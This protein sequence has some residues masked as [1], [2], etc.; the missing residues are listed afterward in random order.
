MKSHAPQTGFNTTVR[1]GSYTEKVELDSGNSATNLISSEAMQEYQAN[2]GPEDFRMSRLE[3]INESA[4]QVSQDTPE[5]GIDSACIIRI[6]YSGVDPQGNKTSLSKWTFCCGTCRPMADRLILCDRELESLGIIPR[7]GE[8]IKLTVGGQPLA[9]VRG[10][11]SPDCF[12][13]IVEKG[14]KN[15]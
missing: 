9:V 8:N 6:V 5:L 15:P 10:S 13:K 3:D 12:Q 2:L 14:F 11:Q 7:E 4:S 1:I